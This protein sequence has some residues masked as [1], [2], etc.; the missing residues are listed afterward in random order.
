MKKWMIPGGVDGCIYLYGLM[1]G[2]TKYCI[3]LYLRLQYNTV[4][5]DQMDLYS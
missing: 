1:E 2:W 5:V 4:F 3:I